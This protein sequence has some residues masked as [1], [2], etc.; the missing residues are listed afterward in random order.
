MICDVHFKME[1]VRELINNFRNETSIR[2]KC[3][4][5]TQIS[6]LMND[7]ASSIPEQKL[8]IFLLKKTWSTVRRDAQSEIGSSL[9]PQAKL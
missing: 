2:K 9:R 1:E 6:K 5:E 7:L 3:L 4:L 8:E